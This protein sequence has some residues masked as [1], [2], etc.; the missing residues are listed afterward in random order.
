TLREFDSLD[1][2]V[3]RRCSCRR[4]GSRRS[5]VRGASA[6]GGCG[7]ACGVGAL[8]GRFTASE[9][10]ASATAVSGAGSGATSWRGCGS[11]ATSVVGT[12]SGAG[13][14]SGSGVGSGFGV[15]GVG[16][17][18]GGGASAVSTG[19]GFGSGV[20][21]A[22]RSVMLSPTSLAFSTI[23]G[24]VVGTGAG[25]SATGGLGS[26]C[27]LWATCSIGTMSA[28]KDSTSAMAISRGDDRL[29]RPKPIATACSASDVVNPVFNSAFLFLKRH[30]PEIAV[31]G[32]GNARHHPHHRAVIGG[33]VAAHIDALVIAGGGDGLELRHDLVDLDLGL[34]EIDAA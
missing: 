15:G 27:A 32:G 29:T 1:A 4:S 18:A 6:R 19:R 11:G 30:Q 10:G 16:L 9:V 17:G 2:A 12:G 26:P 13:F 14:C 5:G 8:A 21:G 25:R 33:A 3:S 20:G 24:R 22:F 28:G 34:L 23:S 7:R 31:A